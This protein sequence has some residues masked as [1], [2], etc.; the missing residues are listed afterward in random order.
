M[1]SVET[2]FD[3]ETRAEVVI[4]FS[5]LG[6]ICEIALPVRVTVRPVFEGLMFANGSFLGLSR[7]EYL[8]FG[9]GVGR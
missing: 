6:L 4:V 3:D 1:T 7:V 5:L 8:D 9:R 2:A